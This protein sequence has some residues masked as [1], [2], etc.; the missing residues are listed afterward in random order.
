MINIIIH[1]EENQGQM[2]RI[3]YGVNRFEYIWQDMI[4]YVFGEDNIEEYFPHAHWH[5]LSG[6]GYHI[7]SSELRP[8]TIAKV[9]D[10]VFILDA[11][12]YKY[13]ITWNPL[14]LPATDSIQKQITYGEYVD[15]NEMADTDKIYNAFLM[16]F[17]CSGEMPYK[18]VSIGTADWKL[19][20]A[21]TPNYNYVLGVLVDTRFLLTLYTKH[22]VV[23]INRLC[24]LIEESLSE[25]R[26]QA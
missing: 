14:H 19:Y 25:Y 10:K 21:Q 17:N 20:S 13:G 2:P 22:N 8:D 12:Y 6:N 3:T 5:I 1:S 16:P 9:Q 4:N 24:S 7:E 26:Q 11:K 15:A 18:F 23:E